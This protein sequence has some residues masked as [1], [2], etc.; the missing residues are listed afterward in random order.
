MNYIEIPP[1]QEISSFVKCFWK[2]E[3]SEK[4]A[5]YTIFPNGYFEL[6]MI[7]EQQNLFSVFLSEIKTKPFVVSIP[8]GIIVSA[9][10]FPLSASEYL[11]EREI[12]SILDITMP[13]NPAFW[14]LKREENLS[15]EDR[16][17]EIS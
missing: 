17:K 2:Y 10:R 11:F 7:F 5:Q 3:N 8:K 9:I 15:F 4:D 12:R 1:P 6:F 13:L 16:T 14:G